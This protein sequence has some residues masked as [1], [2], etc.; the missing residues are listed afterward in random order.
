MAMQWGAHGGRHGSCAHGAHSRPSQWVDEWAQWQCSE[1]KTAN[2]ANYGSQKERCRECGLKK[3]YLD[4]ASTRP[5]SRPLPQGQV[6]MELDAIAVQLEKAQV[7]DVT[8][9]AP[10]MQDIQQDG[11][12]R[13][14]IQA[15]L[16]DLEAALESLPVMQSLAA[17]R[18]GLVDEIKVKKEQIMKVRPLGARIDATREYVA[19]C[20]A[21]RETAQVLAEQARATADAADLEF[22]RA[23]SALEALETELIQNGPPQQTPQN[24]IEEM[25]TALTRVVGEMKGG[26]CVPA[27]L[28]EQTQLHMKTLMDGVRAIAAAAAVAPQAAPA[29]PA[30]PQG[31]QPAAAAVPHAAPEASA[32]AP[33]KRQKILAKGP[34]AAAT[35]PY[36]AVDVGEGE[37]GGAAAQPAA[38][39]GH[40]QL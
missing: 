27:E 3:S 29:A 8:G 14:V 9:P 23:I 6:R 20:Q 21:R 31:T 34:W 30:A 32:A 17:V 36:S 26:S 10:M 35:D 1:C 25:A 4:A 12:H 38:Q 22:A 5:R 28:I 16:K 11:Q 33:I 39:E 24:S 7:V 19:R 18:A 13:K 15:E 37:N 40:P 2:W